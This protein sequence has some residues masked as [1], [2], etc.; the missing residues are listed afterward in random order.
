MCLDLF[1]FNRIKNNKTIFVQRTL[2]NIYR[3]INYTIRK[4][5]IKNILLRPKFYGITSEK[6]NCNTNNNNNN[7]KVKVKDVVVGNT[8]FLLCFVFDAEIFVV[9]VL[10]QMCI[11]SVFSL[12]FYWSVSHTSRNKLQTGGLRFARCRY[13]YLLIN[14]A[15]CVRTTCL[16][17]RL[18]LGFCSHLL[19]GPGSFEVIKP[20]YF[21]YKP[22]WDAERP[23]TTDISCSTVR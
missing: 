1:F 10:L 23:L 8:V 9:L 22:L 20:I 5:T 14:I 17:N 19:A 12:S 7:N 6:K 2:L 4:L 18:L 3:E 13:Y 16:C 15:L 21:E 11:W